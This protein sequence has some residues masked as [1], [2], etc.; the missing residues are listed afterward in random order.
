[1][2]PEDQPPR[3]RRSDYLWIMA[4]LLVWGVYLAVG[5]IRVGGSHAIWR[6]AIVFACTLAFL[7][8]WWVAMFVRQR[9]AE[10]ND[11]GEREA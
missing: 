1:M 6:G 11:A 2:K 3:P 5:A 4:G 9:Q 10:A 7:G 8:L